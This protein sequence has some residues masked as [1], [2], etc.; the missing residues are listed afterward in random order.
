MNSPP[1][2]IKWHK[3]DEEPFDEPD[4]VKFELEHELLSCLKIDN[5][6][7]EIEELL[8]TK[9]ALEYRLKREIEKEENRLLTNTFK[10]TGKSQHEKNIEQYIKDIDTLETDITILSPI[11]RQKLENIP[12]YGEILK[13]SKE[14]KIS[15]REALN[16]I[17]ERLDNITREEILKTQKQDKEIHLIGEFVSLIS[18]MERLNLGK[19]YRRSTDDDKKIENL[20]KSE[21]KIEIIKFIN[22]VKK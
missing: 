6:L 14:N 5:I 20:L 13:Y 9:A 17:I 22:I 2:I 21:K 1:M 11:I 18:S 12:L 4:D 8:Q 10:I 15:I 19:I 16:I 3:A 7:Y